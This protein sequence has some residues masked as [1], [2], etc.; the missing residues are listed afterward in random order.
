LLLKNSGDNNILAIAYNNIEHNL[1]YI[2]PD[3]NGKIIYLDISFGTSADV[4]EVLA[5]LEDVNYLD[6]SNQLI[7]GGELSVV[8][9]LNGEI[10]LI[11]GVFLNAT[12]NYINSLSPLLK[13]LHIRLFNAGMTVIKKGSVIKYLAH[14]GDE[15]ARIENGVFNVSKAKFSIPDPSTYLDPSYI[16]NHISKFNQEGGAFVIRKSD[17]SNPNYTS[18]A[19]RKFVGLKSEMDAVISKYNLENQNLQIL[20]N[21]LDLGENYFSRPN[22]EAYYVIVQPNSSFTFE[23]PNG[24]EGGAYEGY[25]V[26]GGYTKHGTTEAVIANSGNF[27]HNNLVQNLEVIFGQGNVI[28]IK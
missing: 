9:K 21:E 5:V 11:D 12:S 15:I 28:K 26:P 19:P 8:R 23:I 24:N 7:S 3:L 1:A 18:I 20:I 2:D 25:W 6:N 4:Q 22:D 10:K 27:Q 13:S 14:N 16:Q 17:L